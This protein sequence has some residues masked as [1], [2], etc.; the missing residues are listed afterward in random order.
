MAKF[1]SPN[2]GK[3]LTRYTGDTSSIPEGMYSWSIVAGQFGITVGDL[4]LNQ[5]E[6]YAE[7]AIVVG[8]VVQP[9]PELFPVGTN[10]QWL[11]L[12]PEGLPLSLL[13]ISFTS[14]EAP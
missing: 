6:G 2:D 10:W 12:G 5:G 13:P 8:N 1:E 7:S 3:V 14:D 4:F 11:G 9:L